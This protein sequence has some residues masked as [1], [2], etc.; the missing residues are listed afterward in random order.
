MK[1]IERIGWA[2]LVGALLILF[3]LEKCNN[4]PCPVLAKADTVL[5]HHTDTIPAYKPVPKKVTAIVKKIIT[6]TWPVDSTVTEEKTATVKPEDY[7]NEYDCCNYQ[8]IYS[9][10]VKK[11]FGTIVIDDTITNNQLA[12]RKI[13]TDIKQKVI[14][15]RYVDTVKVPVRR[16]QLYAGVD[17]MAGSAMYG[18]GFSL[19]AKT[20]ADKLF[21]AGAVYTNRGWVYQAGYKTKISLNLFNRKK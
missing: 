12:G 1:N 20:K 17:V 7:Y 8:V 2:V 3:L 4:K 6:V 15:N 19:S 21:T 13:T 5:V 11:D 14:T 9:D 18:G 16:F 10:T